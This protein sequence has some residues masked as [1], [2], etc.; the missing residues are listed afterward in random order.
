V[1]IRVLD[2]GEGIRPEDLPHVFDRFYKAAGSTGSGLGLTIA[3]SL[4]AAH[5]GTI[6]AR[7]RGQ[8]GTIIELT[9]ATTTSPAAGGGHDPL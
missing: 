5:G 7:P 2:Q 4:V 8:G 3:R 1:L 9:L 6:A